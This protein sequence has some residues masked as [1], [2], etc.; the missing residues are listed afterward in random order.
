MMI[1]DIFN[2]EGINKDKTMFRSAFR[3]IVFILQALAIISPLLGRGRKQKLPLLMKEGA[4]LILTN[5]NF[6]WKFLEKRNWSIDTIRNLL[7]LRR[8]KR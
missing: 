7:R 1:Y 8:F 6:I 3:S 5:W 2:I 4:F